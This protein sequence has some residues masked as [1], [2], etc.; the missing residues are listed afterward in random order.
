MIK[1]SILHI[2][3]LFT[4]AFILSS[5]NL[6]A[7][8]HRILPLGNSITEGMGEEYIPESQRISY[9]NAL[10]DNL[11]G[12][13]YNFDFVGH[14]N[15][16]YESLSDAD[17]GGIPGTRAQYVARLLQ[18]GYDER[19]NT[20]VTP[21]GEPYLDVY[22]ADIILLHI[23]TNDI[24]HAEGSSAVDMDNILDIIDAWELSSGTKVVVFVARIIQRTDNASNSLTTTQLN[25]N[26]ASMIA[27]RGDPNIIM[28]NLETGAGINYNTELLADGVHPAPSAYDKMGQKWYSSLNTYLSAIPAPPG[29]LSLG[30]ETG[31]SIQLSWA[32]NSNNETGFE[33]ERSTTSSESS[34]TLIHTTGS[35]TTS[36]TDTGLE[37]NTRYYYRVRAINAVGP[38]LYTQIESAFTSLAP[39]APTG[40]LATPVNEATIGL[41]WSD[42]TASET[43][44]IIERS[45]LS[46][47]GFSL[48]YT[49]SANVTSYD[50]LGLDEGTEYFYRVRATNGVVE[51]EDSNEASATTN[52]LPPTG[53]KAS[54]VNEG[55]ISLTWSD[56]SNLET[57]YIIE[58]S[59]TSG[60]GFSEVHTTAA[61]A[62]SYT[63]SGLADGR[64]YVY[65]VRAT[66]GQTVSSYSNESD[67]ST[68]LAAPSQLSA[69]ALDEATIILTW[70]DNSV[71]ETGYIIERSLT[72]G[73]GY[74]V[75]DVIPPNSTSYT[76]SGFKEGDQFFYLIRATNGVTHSEPSNEANSTTILATPV[77][78]EATGVDKASINLMWSDNSETET[79]FIVERSESPGAGYTEIHTTAANE[80]FYSDKGLADGT[81]Y[82]YR[83]RATNGEVF[84][85]YSNESGAITNLSV[86]TG[87]S[88]SAIDEASINLAWTD[89]SVS[90]EGYIIERSGSSEAGFTVIG[91]TSANAVEYRDTD[92]RDGFQYFYRV[93]ATNVTGSSAYSNESD[94]I[95]ILAAPTGLSAILLDKASVKLTWTDNSASETGYIIEQSESSGTGFAEIDVALANSNS[96]TDDGIKEGEYFFYRVRAT[97]QIAISAYSNEAG[98][99]P[100]MELTDSL[101]SFYPNPSSGN[102]TMIIRRGEE[103]DATSYVRLADL[104][105][106]VHFIEEIEMT[107]GMQV[108]MYEIELPP[109]ISSGTYLLS[110]ITG[111]SSASEKFILVRNE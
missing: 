6:K 71:S 61:N 2:I 1:S 11:T 41:S 109:T 43:G 95:T 92:L 65:R 23:G 63:D 50:D 94:A 91:T 81:Q 32:D 17:H 62:T 72:S 77:G 19:W 60:S 35:G 70:A 86:P 78:L 89:H 7:Q 39:T 21:G 15:A 40:L 44:Y 26:V 69:T 25:D 38:S 90:E 101:F 55:M 47:M 93:R 10:F 27:G 57:G 74:G 16:G 68:V 103:N 108:Q 88:A 98:F 102:I 52:L 54:V 36:Y 13:G 100:N 18:D 79:G 51:S 76:D 87:M 83:V 8:T 4:V 104:S 106:K 33:I 84:S 111:N 9:R 24:T 20:Q 99:L 82:Y 22:P 75:I 12:G 58:R 66:N 37:E 31:S 67:A 30:G 46:G 56:Q 42:N 97:N 45:A 49:T 80:T 34:F 96:Y 28:V 64:K 29:G 48:I 105:G 53:M 85:A 110:V 73:S 107:N 14:R 5:D 59:E 3:L